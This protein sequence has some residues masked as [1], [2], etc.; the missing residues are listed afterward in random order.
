[1]DTKN[2]MFWLQLAGSVSGILAAIG[3]LFTP[4]T[5]A[6]KVADQLEGVHGKLDDLQ[7]QIGSPK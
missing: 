1:M 4:N 6:S 5:V 3:H 7:K 2:P